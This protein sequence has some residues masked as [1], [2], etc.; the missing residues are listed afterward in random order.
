MDPS[1][2]CDNYVQHQGSDYACANTESSSVV[3]P[4][5]KCRD[6][7]KTRSSVA[8]TPA[9]SSISAST[10]EKHSVATV[11]LPRGSSDPSVRTKEAAEDKN[12]NMSYHKL[13]SD[14][15]LGKS[16][17][18]SSAEFNHPSTVERAHDDSQM[19]LETKA[20][21]SA[22]E[23]VKAIIHTRKDS[24]KKKIIGDRH[25]ADKDKEVLDSN[26]GAARE[27]HR[28]SDVVIDCFLRRSTPRASPVIA[29]QQS[30]AQS[31]PS[32]EFSFAKSSTSGTRTSSRHS[33]S[34][35]VK[36][37]NKPGKFVTV[38]TPS[39]L[40]YRTHLRIS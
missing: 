2:W 7:K 21:R 15:I 24:I 26:T 9:T 27:E 13:Q 37:T 20:Y 1:D 36:V 6:S 28:G 3:E 23:R 39:S 38:R 17:V 11:L 25:S 4:S 5:G 33:G 40:F 10:E 16:S 22:W 29:R 35:N 32:T 14:Q 12:V 30:V 19:R 31:P 18:C 34:E 8:P